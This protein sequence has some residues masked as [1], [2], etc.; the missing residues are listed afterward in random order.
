[1]RSLLLQYLKRSE[2]L[3]EELEAVV[4]EMEATAAEVAVCTDMDTSGYSFMIKRVASKT[5]MR[6][7]NYCRLSADILHGDFVLH[8]F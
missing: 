8:F 2:C 4:V 1:M 3:S 6:L 5:Y 7:L